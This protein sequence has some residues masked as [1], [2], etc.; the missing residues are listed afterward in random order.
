[1]KKLF[2][3]GWKD[4]IL[5]FSTLWELAFFIILPIVFTFLVAGGAPSGEEDGRI[6]LVVVDQAQTGL[7]REIIA[8]LEDSTSVNI[9]LLSLEEADSAFEGRRAE[10]VLILPADLTAEAVQAGTAR[11]V[12]RQQPNSLNASIATRAVQSAMR[13]VSGTVEA[14]SASVREAEAHAP[15]ASE[16]ERQ[17]Y[18]QQSLE[19]AQRIQSQTPDRITIVEGSTPDQV[20]YD[21]RANA[22]AG[23]L[24]TW[25]FVPLLGISAMF[26]YERDKGTLRRMLTTPTTRT[27]YL[28]GTIGGQ[29]FMALIQMTLLILFGIFVMKLPWGREPLALFIL[30]TSTALAGSAIGAAMGTFIKS[31]GQATS[32]SI[33]LGMLMALLGGCWY[34]LELFPQAVQSAVRVLPTT[35][36]MD[37]LVDLSV[38]GGGFADILPEA[39]VLLGFAV[40]FL[41]IGVRRFRYE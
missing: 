15:F 32:L 2:A 28:A 18:F 3:I 16:A 19:L 14:A 38:R 9:E 6:P 23:Q 30:L 36:A 4:A 1:M 8:A 41:I 17:V 10:V 24:L 20:T 25:V 21:P 39:G 37:G 40:L 5:R 34:P 7:S 13:G 11:V 35:W 12:F 26:A 33:M 22:S 27:T 29:V 31:E